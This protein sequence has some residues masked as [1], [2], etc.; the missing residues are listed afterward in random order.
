LRGFWGGWEELYLCDEELGLVG[1]DFAVETLG[2][3][4]WKPLFLELSE[5]FNVFGLA[6]TND[7]FR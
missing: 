6:L 5:L 3:T 7:S 4:E 1:E 2:V